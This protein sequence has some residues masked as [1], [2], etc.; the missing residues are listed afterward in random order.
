MINLRRVSD[1]DCRLIWQWAN[2]PDVR[3]VSFSADAIIYEYHVKWFEAKLN[4]PNC[5]FY[6][7]ENREQESIG[8][9]RF[10]IKGNQATISISLSRKFRGQGYGSKIIEL[11]SQKIFEVSNV[12]VIHAYVKKENVVSLKVFQKAG[13]M[14][15]D[16]DSAVGEQPAF[17]IIR[18]KKSDNE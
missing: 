15:F 1:E 2:D 11:A 12:D 6:I 18:E 7:A 13:F 5:Y 14:V 4:N 3:V 10:D 8:Q 16:D 9:V 17:H